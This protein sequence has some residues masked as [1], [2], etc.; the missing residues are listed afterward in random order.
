[1]ELK[2]KKAAERSRRIEEVSQ[3]YLLSIVAKKQRAVK[4]ILRMP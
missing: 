4:R 2:N 1:M 3:A